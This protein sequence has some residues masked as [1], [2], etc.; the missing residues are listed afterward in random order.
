MKMDHNLV[1]AMLI[2]MAAGEYRF[3]S[4]ITDRNRLHTERAPRGSAAEADR[5]AAAEAKRAR[6]AARGARS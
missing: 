2:G 6:K 3:P 4:R 1:A 5:M